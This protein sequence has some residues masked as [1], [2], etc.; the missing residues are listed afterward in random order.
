[1]Q[2]KS[3]EEVYDYLEKNYDSK[4]EWEFTTAL[5][6]LADSTTEE[7]AKEKLKWESFVFDFTLENGLVNPIHS[8]VKEDGTTLYA[9]PSYDD[10]GN[11][12][13]PYVKER[14]GLAKNDHLIA[15]YNQVLWNSPRPYK[16]QQQ[17]KN[18]ADAYLR[19]LDNLNCTREEKRAGRDC[20]NLMKNGFTL[21]LQVKYKVDEYKALVNSWLF[22]TRKFPKYLK[23]FLLKY[24]L[25]LPQIKNTDFDGCLDLIKKIGRDR[26]KEKADYFFTKEAYETALK[27]AQRTGSDTKIW[28]KRIGDTHVRMADHRMDDETRMIPLTFLKE[29]IPYYKLAGLNKKVKEVEQRYFELKKELKLSKFEVPLGDET[30]DE[31]SKYLDAKTT[32]LMDLTPDEIY[33]YLL[34]G[35]DI[36]PNKV[37]LKEMGRDR[38]NAFA[39]LAVTM[40]FDINN[41]VSRQKDSKEVKE[42][43]KIHENYSLYINLT[44]LPFLHRIFVEGIKQG[45]LTHKNLIQFILENTWLGQELS[46]YDSGGDIVKYR[47]ISLIA[48]SIHEYFLQTGSA[49]KSNN[50]YTTYI[51]PID[52]LTLKFEGVLRDFAKILKVP[53]TVTGKG[54]VLREKYIE[55][56]LAEKEIQKYFDENDLLF[57]NYLFVAKDGMNLR[58]NI[59][60]SFYRYQN[61]NFQLMHLLICAFLRIGK[62]KLSIK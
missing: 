13:L 38:N 22:R 52:S 26:S 30:S 10:F 45:K 31:L 19:I 41:N 49:L 23:I 61:Y 51:L 42:K 36:F 5:K 59:A 34:T 14:A 7:S 15:R 25:D 29:S 27:I 54:N 57:F 12:G 56:L 6:K 18:A 8:S 20:L 24:M 28:N 58:N 43:T 60:H 2:F 50:P 4:M 11:N 35:V 55:E 17:A 40:R 21:S 33:G 48:P 47:W 32:K 37:W 16:R 44:V 9:Y 62:Y 53:T 46:D 3:I 39:D 1:M